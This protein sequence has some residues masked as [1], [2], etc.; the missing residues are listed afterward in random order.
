MAKERFNNAGGECIVMERSQRTP[1]TALVLRP[2]NNLTPYI[3]ICGHKPG[4]T[5]WEHGKYFSSLSEALK[6]LESWDITD[7]ADEADET[8]V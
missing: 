7:D 6:E 2:D 3:V 4:D 8:E 1:T 5:S